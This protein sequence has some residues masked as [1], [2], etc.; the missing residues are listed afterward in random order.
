MVTGT[1]A[2]AIVLEDVPIG[3]FNPRPY[4][5]NVARQ[6]RKTLTL[7]KL[8][9]DIQQ[10]HLWQVGCGMIMRIVLA[11]IPTLGHLSQPLE[12]RF[13]TPAP[14]GYAKHRLPVQKA[15]IYPLATSGINEATTKGNNEVVHD[16]VVTQIK[17]KPEWFDVMLNMVCGDQMTTDRL[18][19]AVR[20]RS[21]D[22]NAFEQRR[23]VLPV[24]QIWHMKHAF[25]K[26]IFN[27]HWS[28][29]VAEGV[30]GLRHAIEALGHR[31]NA[32]DCD[33][34]PC[35]DA[36]KVVFDTFILILFLGQVRER[37]GAQLTDAA[38]KKFSSKSHML[39]ELSAYFDEGEPLHAVGLEVLDEI[40]GSVYDNYLTTS[41]YEAAISSDE[42]LEPSQSRITSLTAE[43]LARLQDPHVTSSS[44]TKSS[45]DSSSPSEDEKPQHAKASKSTMRFSLASIGDQG[46]ATAILLLRDSFWYFEVA[47]AVAEGDI[48][49]VMEVIKILRIAFWGGGATNYGNELLE[50][51][52]NHFY[53]YPADLLKA[54]LNNYLVNPSGLPG[55]FHELDL[56][57]EHHNLAIKTVFNS[58]NSDFDSTF[59][60]DSV[61][62]NIIGLAGL[63]DSLLYLLGLNRTPRGKTRSEYEA[64]INV[65]AQHYRGADSI[66]VRQPAR[67]HRF[68]PRDVFGLGV[69]R[70]GTK[71]PGD[72]LR[73]TALEVPESGL[74]DAEGEVP[75]AVMGAGPAYMDNEAASVLGG[76]YLSLPGDNA[77]R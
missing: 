8:L 23:W 35:H 66:L 31:I 16:L 21:K 29:L 73:R 24:A 55:H 57:Q 20:Y 70:L 17:M 68:L 76:G 71:S 5:E 1:A 41:A 67:Q 45:S 32:L 75:P 44:G 48:G 40:A 19:K 56:L 10:D 15:E 59:M 30:F 53:E 12:A 28:P 36:L 13:C 14:G 26:V 50:M 61:A 22:V 11:H 46:L 49:R 47:T 51:A 2:T 42:D 7:D 52:C 34:Y 3:A 38:R 69:D 65:L 77:L 27:V 33:F 4:E 43:V 54:V 39:E 60:K 58:K 9:A 62:L 72:F 6:E 25:L 37:F 63:R 18:R 64:D 74:D